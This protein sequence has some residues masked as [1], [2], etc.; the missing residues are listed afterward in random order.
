MGFLIAILFILFFCTCLGN[1]LR[2]VNAEKEDKRII[3]EDNMTDLQRYRKD[4]VENFRRR[5]SFIADL[6]EFFENR[7]QAEIWLSKFV[8]D[9]QLIM[10]EYDEEGWEG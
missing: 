10:D 7:S 8:E 2:K 3:K 6:M 5:E 4:I 9:Y 1:T